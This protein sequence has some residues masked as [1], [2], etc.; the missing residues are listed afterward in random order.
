MK[1]TSYK[2][3]F[4][5]VFIFLSI[6]VAQAQYTTGYGT[7]YGSFGL[8]MATQNMYTAS[9]MQMRR[10]MARNAMI[11]KWGLAAVE[12]AERESA[13]KSSG[14][15]AAPVSNPQITVPPPRVVHNYGVF[16]P[17]ATVDTGKAL[18]EA[19]GDTPEE[20]ALIT[21]I[22]ITTKSGYEAAAAQKGWKN[23]IAGGMTFFTVTAMTIYRDADE[24]GDE[25]VNTYYKVVNAAL[26]EMP[27]FATVTN[28]DKQNFNNMLIGFS[29]LLLAGYTEGKQNNDA[30]TIDTYKKLAGGL[31]QLVLKTD[32]ENLQIVN[33][34]I[35]FK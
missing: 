29:G 27:A 19:L 33:G 1:R 5:F 11:Q 31:I 23:N 13:A 22:F 16:R 35:V 21:K 18:A 10:T 3:T 15:K 14:A 24:P 9:Q 30:A 34:Q 28:K 20:K 26:D 7:V 32:P 12:K 2:L 6:S 8:A 25:A 17:D 4:S